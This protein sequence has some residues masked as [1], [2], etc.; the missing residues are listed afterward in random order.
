MHI[1]FFIT[2]QQCQRSWV[3]KNQLWTDSFLGWKHH[4]SL[5]LFVL[6]SV[7][8]SF[9]MRVIAQI[10]AISLACHVVRNVFKQI[11]GLP[12]HAIDA[13]CV[14]LSALMVANGHFLGSRSGT[15][16]IVD[17]AIIGTFRYMFIFPLIALLSIAL[18]T[19]L[20][21]HFTKTI[22]HLHIACMT[23]EGHGSMRWGR[24]LA[25]LCPSADT[26]FLGNFP[27]FLECR[28]V[29]EKGV[30]LHT[31]TCFLRWK[32]ANGHYHAT[33]VCKSDMLV[34]LILPY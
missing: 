24:S 2:F 32:K 20:L 27:F 4:G 10:G 8:H 6:H 7:L 30:F 23:V 16:K 1:F 11:I 14:I 12:W 3:R 22:E 34:A 29:L 17:F 28:S 21:K 5:C 18:M 26:L 31:F 15:N 33:E 25:C 19:S 13:S 9:A